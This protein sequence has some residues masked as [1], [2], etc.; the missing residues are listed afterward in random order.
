[1]SATVADRKIV[2]DRSADRKATPATIGGYVI[3]EDAVATEQ[4]L[5]KPLPSNHCLVTTA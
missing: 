5:N 2:A 3:H 1:M 4:L